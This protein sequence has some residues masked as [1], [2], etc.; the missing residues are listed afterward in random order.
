MKMNKQNFLNDVD[1]NSFVKWLENNLSDLRICLQ[2]KASRFVPKGI[3]IELEGIE[4][5]LENY[6]WRSAEM[7]VGNW[8]ETKP[9]LNSLSNNLRNAITANNQEDTLIACKAILTWGGNRNWSTGAFP[10]LKS[11][12]TSSPPTLCQYIKSS[13]NAFNL[14]TANTLAIAPPVQK[15]NSMLTKVHALYAQDGLPIYDSR[16]AAAI[17]SLVEL[18]RIDSDLTMAP[19]PPAL[20]FPATLPTRTIFKRFPDAT[21]SP[22]VMTYSDAR[23]PA[24][25]SGA[26]IRLSWIMEA[27]LNRLPHL[28]VTEGAISNRMHAFEASL[29]VIGYDVTCLR[30]EASA[31]NASKYKKK[32]KALLKPN[33][34]IIP[35][36]MKALQ[37][38]SGQNSEKNI[39]YSGTLEH[40]FSVYWGDIQFN[41][42][43]EDISAILMEFGGLSDIPLGAS[44]TLPRPAGSL[45]QWLVNNG[46][47]SARYASAIAP[48]LL[49][50]G[51]ITNYRGKKPILLTFK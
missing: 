18:W 38:L 14:P 2:I 22:G 10:F 39:R 48:I 50:E 28:F 35:S 20:T 9:Y 27:V 43:A 4:A 7:Q 47:S 44:Q 30:C 23:T 45:G 3:E 26:K 29:F 37:S 6:L 24:I 11:L 41:L 42:G 36:D 16:V 15:M 32:V 21:H 51:I 33:S 8:H 19:L 1:V 5:V 34:S 12:A 49:Q 40:G 13:G 25:W 46:W 17:A 31:T